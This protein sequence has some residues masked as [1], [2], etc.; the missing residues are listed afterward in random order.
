MTMA[1]KIVVLHDVE[2]GGPVFG[3]APG[4]LRPPGKAISLKAGF[5]GSAAMNFIEGTVGVAG[6]EKVGVGRPPRG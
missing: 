6:D 1:E 4:R 5:I 2:I 3:P